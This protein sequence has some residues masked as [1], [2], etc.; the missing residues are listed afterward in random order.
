MELQNAKQKFE[1]Q[2]IK[3]AAISYDS[4]AILKDFAQRHQIEYPLLADPD[5]KIIRSFQVFNAG[6]SGKEKGMAYPGYF[7]IDPAG[8][9]RE[10]YFEEK[11]TDRLTPNS[12]I[13]KLFPE[14]A[15]EVTGSAERPNLRLT[16]EQSDRTVSPGNRVTLAAKIELPPHVHVYAP[17][18][19]GYK[20]IQLE[21]QAPSGIEL[22]RVAY[23]NSKTLYLEA[24]QEHVPVFEGQ[25]RISQ[26]ATVIFS[27]ASD[28]ARA[29]ASS[30][31]TIT[32][33]GDLKY[34]ACD[35]RVCYPPASVPVSWTLK[36]IPLDIRRSP[37][38]IRHK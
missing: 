23:P 3:L 20:P 5:S 30:T 36:V 16:L 9:I 33:K 12:L 8:T 1:N 28:V 10:K 31:K 11:Y 35:N 6:A 4:Q 7:Y 32:I 38:A 24:I 21:V 22:G 26:D 15:E 2:G 14:L 19:E 34:Q 29:L 17:G 13:G 25:F 27:P 37:N 18:V